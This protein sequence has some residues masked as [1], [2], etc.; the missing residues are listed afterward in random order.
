[1]TSVAIL[2]YIIITLNKMFCYLSGDV[3][4]SAVIA[5]SILHVIRNLFY[6]AR[7]ECFIKQV[8]ILSNIHVLV[9][10]KKT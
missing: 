9:Y 3:H 4:N 10:E 2:G 6:E 5:I 7:H 8:Y 1:M